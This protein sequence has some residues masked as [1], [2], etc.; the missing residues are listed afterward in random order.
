MAARRSIPRLRRAG[1]LVRRALADPPP[2][3]PA[4][5]P[6][7]AGSARLALAALGADPRRPRLLAG[8]ARRRRPGRVASPQQLLLGPRLPPLRRQAETGPGADRHRP[9]PVL[10][11][12]AAAAAARLQTA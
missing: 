12:A 10:P 4:P 5:S 2:A 11:P 8:G 7:P 9:G 6:L 1:P 3:P